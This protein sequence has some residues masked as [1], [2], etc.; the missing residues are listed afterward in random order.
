MVV[1]AMVTSSGNPIVTIVLV[2]DVLAA[3]VVSFE[4]PRN[5]TVPPNEAV[6]V[7][8]PSDTVILEFSMLAFATVPVSCPAGRLVRDAPEPLKVVA[9]RVFTP[10]RL[11]DIS[12]LPLISREPPSISPEA[13]RVVTPPIA[14]LMVAAAKVG[15]A[16]VATFCPI[17]NSPPE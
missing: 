3:T 1:P 8:D 6:L 11:P 5:L 13:V 4:V 9:V 15:V 16:E 2:N 12:A 17:E 14:P 7:F 10:V